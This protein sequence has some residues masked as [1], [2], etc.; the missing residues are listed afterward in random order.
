VRTLAP[1]LVAAPP[2][3][4]RIRAR[5][6]LQADDEQVLWVVGEY[7]GRLAGQDW[8]GVAGSAGDPTSAPTA[9]AL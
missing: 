7:L 1:V 5:L 3:G 8:P 4:A 6:R 2:S 9:S